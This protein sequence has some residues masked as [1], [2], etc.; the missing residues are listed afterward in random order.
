M[1]R[2]CRV[3]VNFNNHISHVPLRE[4]SAPQKGP[5][6]LLLLQKCC[7]DLQLMLVASPEDRYGSRHLHP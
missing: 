2:C 1:V 4:F 7:A 5:D 6:W 3:E